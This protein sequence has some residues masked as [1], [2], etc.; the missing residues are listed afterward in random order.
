VDR[1]RSGRGGLVPLDVATGLALFDACVEGAETAVV[2]VGLDLRTLRALGEAVPPLLSRLVGGST[3]RRAVSGRA[4]TVDAPRSLA[5]RLA[6][7][8]TEAER[9]QVLV[10]LVCTEV[11]AVLGHASADEIDPEQAFKDLGFDSL[12]SVE[13]R[14]RLTASTGRRLPATLVFDYPNP[15]DLAEHLRSDIVLAD[16]PTTDIPLLGQLDRLETALAALN[17]DRDLR[18]NVSARLRDLLV[19]CDGHDRR[20]VDEMNEVDEIESATADEIF[21]LIDKEFGV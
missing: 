12:T 6:E 1:Q 7:R 5:Q 15:R 2:P 18:R 9:V 19:R 8:A 13:L 20:P 14:N 16:A 11:A 10:D 21:D 4:D 17:G 3:R